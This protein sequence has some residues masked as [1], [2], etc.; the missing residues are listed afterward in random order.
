M[1]EIV[2]A[3]FGGQG[4]LTLGRIIAAAGAADGQNVSWIPSYGSE[5]RGG[6]AN[7]NL[8]ISA[9]PIASPYV[10]KIDVLVAL[11][12]ES[13]ADFGSMVKKGGA[14]IVNSSIVENIPEFEG[15][16]V[17]EVPANEIAMREN[18]PKG[19]NLVLVGAIIAHANPVPLEIAKKAVI[20]YFAGKKANDE[21]N[22]AALTAGYNYVKNIDSIKAI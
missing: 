21:L 6:A 19:M 10:R 1:I 12:E 18:N 14:V 7:C 15:V 13:L 11:N 17:I 16:T 9:E 8:K 4:V 20:D 22:L 3:G 5:M 2:C